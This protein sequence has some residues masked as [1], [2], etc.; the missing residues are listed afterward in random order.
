M[1][2]KQKLRSLEKKMQR[3]K[4]MDF[5][6]NEAVRYFHDIEKYYKLQQE[7]FRLNFEI[8]HCQTCGKKLC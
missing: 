3:M 8:E 2:Q 7:Y 6:L 4:R 5:D 1:T